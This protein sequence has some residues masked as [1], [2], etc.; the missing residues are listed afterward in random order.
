MLQLGTFE[1]GAQCSA[2]HQLVRND[3]L[4]VK[5]GIRPS[6]SEQADQVG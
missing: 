2:L 6:G 5:P 1:S 3:R 4:L